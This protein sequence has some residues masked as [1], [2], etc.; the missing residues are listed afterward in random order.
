MPKGKGYSS[1]PIQLRHCVVKSFRCKTKLGLSLFSI[2]S[3]RS[4][5]FFCS[6]SSSGGG[7]C[8]AWSKN[9]IR[10]ALCSL[11]S[12]V[13]LRQFDQMQKAA[14][15]DVLGLLRVKTQTNKSSKCVGAT[16]GHRHTVLDFNITHGAFDFQACTHMFEA[17]RNKSGHGLGLA[18]VLRIQQVH[19]LRC[20]LKPNASC[21]KTLP[22]LYNTS[23]CKQKPNKNIPNTTM[24]T[25]AAL[26]SPHWIADFQA[27]TDS[28]S[29]QAQVRLCTWQPT[30]M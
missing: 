4:F 11:H 16:E 18:H 1:F 13:V 3:K 12:C 14:R 15:P 29:S 28:L 22:I 26:L 20:E 19:S 21:I 6:S 27:S 30:C 9:A 25:T 24:Q 7:A 2:S 5:R 10:A 8:A 17:G 23:V